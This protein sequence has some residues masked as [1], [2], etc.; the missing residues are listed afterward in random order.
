MKIFI[1]NNNKIKD[2]HHCGVSTLSKLANDVTMSLNISLPS[3]TAVDDDKSAESF[4][5]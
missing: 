4:S 2:V 5:S 3:F 1:N